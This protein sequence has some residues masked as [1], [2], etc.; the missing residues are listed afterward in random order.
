MVISCLIT[1]LGSQ[2]KLEAY[3]AADGEA[4]SVLKSALILLPM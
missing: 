2:Q 4:Q 1:D 3:H